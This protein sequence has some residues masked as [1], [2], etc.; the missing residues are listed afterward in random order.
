VSTLGLFTPGHSWVHRAAPGTKLLLLLLAGAASFLVRH[1]WQVAVALGVVVAGYLA[2][3]LSLRVLLRQAR[4]LLWLLVL[5]GGVH[6]LV[7]GWQQAV[8]V[9]GVILA[10]V[11]LAGLVTLTTRTT[12]LV[13]TAVRALRPLRRVGVDPERVGLLLALAVRS[14]PVVAALAQEVRDAQRARGLAASPR[15]F[16][17]PLIIRS[18]RHADALG[19]ALVAR[20]VDD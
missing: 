12:D 5:V 11:L 6:V 1:P 8:V 4:P 16:A 2:A 3:G 14:V 18:L 9:T 19:E 7:T 13:D 10:L 17:V 20:G 15:A